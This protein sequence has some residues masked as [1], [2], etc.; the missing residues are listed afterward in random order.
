MLLAVSLLA[1]LPV[2]PFDVAEHP[3]NPNPAK[4]KEPTVSNVL[5]VMFIVDP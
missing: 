3:C 1:V 2:L 4:I 5:H